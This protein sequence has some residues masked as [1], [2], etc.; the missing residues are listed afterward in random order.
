[1]SLYLV[2]MR[3]RA[4][5]LM[6]QAVR[7]MVVDMSRSLRSVAVSRWVMARLWLDRA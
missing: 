6:K 7:G 2:C 1:M 4:T 3:H 5:P